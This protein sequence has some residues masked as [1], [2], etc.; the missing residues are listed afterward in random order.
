[1]NYVKNISVTTSIYNQFFQI[2]MNCTYNI[3]N[4]NLHNTLIG[5]NLL[6]L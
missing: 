4:Q 6:Y 2:L 3:D 1:M 5:Y